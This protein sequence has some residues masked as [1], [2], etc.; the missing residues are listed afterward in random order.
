MTVQPTLLVIEDEPATRNLL[1]S[2]LMRAGF[3]VI[4]AEDGRTGLEIVKSHKPDLVLLDLRLPTIR[5]L[6]VLRQIRGHPATARLPVIILTAEAEE[7]DRIIGLELGAD[8]YVTKPFSP[9]ELVARVST[10]LRRAA[11]PPSEEGPILQ[12]GELTIDAARH[13]VT[14]AGQPIVLTATE[15]RI[16]Q[17]LA[18]RAGKVASREDISS[19]VRDGDADAL[20]RTI[21]AHIKAIRRKLGHGGTA[22]ETIRGFGYKMV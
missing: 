21:D 20:D 6:D 4:V 14:F 22:I 15:F 5:G 7:T 19:A 11:T 17:F 2:M 18:S 9:R 1:N 3:D 8:D 13:S 16:L 12:R 10:V